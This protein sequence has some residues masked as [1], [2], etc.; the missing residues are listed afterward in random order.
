MTVFGCL[1]RVSPRVTLTVAGV[2]EAPSV[3]VLISTG[4][5]VSGGTNTDTGAVL[6]EAAGEARDDGVAEGTEGADGTGVGMNFGCAGDMMGCK[7]LMVGTTKLVL[8]ELAGFCFL[9]PI[10][11]N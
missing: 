9:F 4:N 7:G 11:K 8:R 10:W 2:G 1:D 6:S 3:V 5:V